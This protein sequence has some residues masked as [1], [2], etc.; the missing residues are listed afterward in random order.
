MWRP[1]RIAASPGSAG[2]FS[3]PAPERRWLAGARNVTAA[4]TERQIMERWRSIVGLED[5]K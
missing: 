3:S 4:K 5:E 2:V 1:P